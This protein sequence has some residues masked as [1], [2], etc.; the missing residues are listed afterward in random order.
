MCKRNVT[1]AI[2]VPRRLD[3]ALDLNKLI[4]ILGLSSDQFDLIGTVFSLA[5]GV[6]GIAGLFFFLQR[7]EVLPRYRTSMTLLCLVSV[8]ATYN[9]VRLYS[10]W[11]ESFVVLNG[12]ITSTGVPYNDTFRYADW[13]TTVPL[14]L[15]AFVSV[16][17][18]PARL[19]RLRST[20]LALLGAEMIALGYFGQVATNIE[21][22]WVWFGVGMIPFII[23]M[24]QLY[25]N[26]G[27]AIE[28]EPAGARAAIKLARL[29]LLLSWPIYAI[30]YVL[31]LIGLK[32]STVFVGIQVGYAVADITA[33]AFYGLF[34]WRAATAKSAPDIEIPVWQPASARSVNA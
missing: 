21:T 10:S 26:L 3:L 19:I 25:S 18:L 6:M 22:R 12:V 33:K 24:V 16:L 7:S 34:I 32:G 23:I 29:G 28:A 9:Y 5:I 1:A 8:I 15:V 31:P 14:L 11:H 20:V 13:L 4:W 27:K 30:V 17:D 2:A